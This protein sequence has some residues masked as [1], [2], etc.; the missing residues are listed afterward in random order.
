MSNARYRNLK[1]AAPSIGDLAV[2]RMFSEP[3]KPRGRWRLLLP[4]LWVVLAWLAVGA[5]V[6]LLAALLS[7][8]S[9]NAQ[10]VDACEKYDEAVSP[11]Y[12]DYVNS[13]ADLT[14]EQKARR[15]ATVD[16]FR[17]AVRAVRGK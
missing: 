14:P 10:L 5:A 13:D 17:N 16:D 2:A 11:E 4:A 3:V 6:L 15:R 12:L 9:F 8:C 1:P 7:G